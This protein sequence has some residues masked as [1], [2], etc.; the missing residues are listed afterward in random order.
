[1]LSLPYK[2]VLELTL[3]FLTNNAMKRNGNCSWLGP[4]GS[5]SQINDC[6]IIVCCFIEVEN[7]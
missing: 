2:N 6:Y 7:T 1:M 5:L 4:S 3:Q